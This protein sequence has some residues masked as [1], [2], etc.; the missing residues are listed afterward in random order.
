MNANGQVIPIDLRVEAGR[1]L[2]D[3]EQR[4]SAIQSNASQLPQAEANMLAEATSDTMNTLRFL[5]PF[6]LEKFRSGS[7]PT[8]A[9]F[10]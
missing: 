1:W 3:L 10:R 8:R 6:L 4:V 7:A 5:G 9:G 2:D